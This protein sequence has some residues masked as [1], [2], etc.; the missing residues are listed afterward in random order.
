[1]CCSIFFQTCSPGA[2]SQQGRVSICIEAVT[3]GY[4]GGGAKRTL[5]ITGICLF[6]QETRNYAEGS[7]ILSSINPFI[8]FLD[9]VAFAPN[10]TVAQFEHIDN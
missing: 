10:Q 3:R 2:A 7:S 5:C 9:Q 4:G 6:L 8:S 1:M